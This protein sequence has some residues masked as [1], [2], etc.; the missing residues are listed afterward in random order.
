MEQVSL[1]CQKSVYV[2]TAL[3]DIVMKVDVW[4]ME[5]DRNKAGYDY[6]ARRTYLGQLEVDLTHGNHTGRMTK[7]INPNE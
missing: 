4:R 5:A 2:Y 3:E 7:Q 6:M 1:S